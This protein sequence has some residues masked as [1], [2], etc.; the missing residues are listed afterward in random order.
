MTS[1]D[2]FTWRDGDRLIAFGRGR[3]TTEAEEILGH[4]YVLL[5]TPRAAAAAPEVAR[6]AATVI[7]IGP[8]R[9]DELAAELVDAAARP[10]DGRIVALGGGR[11]VD[12]AK[13]L[14]SAWAETDERWAGRVAAVPTTLS[15]A[16]MTRGHRRAVGHSGPGVRPATVLDDPALSGSQPAPDLAASALNALGHAYEAPLTTNANAVTTAVAEEAARL[17]VGAWNSITPGDDERDALALGALLAGWAMDIT[18]YGLHHVM[19][20]TLVRFAGV[21]HGPAN[22]IMLPFTTRALQ[23]RF[24]ARIERLSEAL[25]ADPSSAAAEL[26]K[27]SGATRLRDVGVTEAQLAECA[28]QAAKRPDLAQTPPPADRTELLA[29][30]EEAW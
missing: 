30:Y 1:A 28:D 13:A 10:R 2:P 24:P 7:E 21:G 17:L 4:S 5:T 23:R 12:V 27:R 26:T 16:Q 22:A 20:Q 6:L 11:V 25:G 9:V 18:G 8:G 19:S 14:G 15:A 29:L 3:A